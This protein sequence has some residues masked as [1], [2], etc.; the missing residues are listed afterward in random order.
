MKRDMYI[1]AYV[2]NNVFNLRSLVLKFECE[3]S[4]LFNHL[5][6]WEIARRTNIVR[7]HLHIYI[8]IYICT[9]NYVSVSYS[10]TKM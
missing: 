5:K 4:Q 1:H 10:V 3:S 7:Q 8:C 9:Y 6:I 2:Y